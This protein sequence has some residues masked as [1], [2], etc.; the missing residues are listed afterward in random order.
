MP[1]YEYRCDACGEGIEL[2]QALGAGPPDEGCPSCAGCVRRVFSRVAIRY[3]AWG[4]G[5]TDA[6]VSD[7]RGKDYKALRERAERLSDEKL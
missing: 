2:L 7:T 1:I 4:F 3:G 5:C 6:L